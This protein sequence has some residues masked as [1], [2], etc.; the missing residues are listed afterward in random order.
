MRRDFRIVCTS[1]YFD[2]LHVG[3]VEYLESARLLG[4][5]LIVIL[6]ADRQRNAVPRVPIE[7]RI[8]ILKALQVVDQVVVSVDTN[9]HVGETLRQIHPTIFAKGLCASNV[10][11]QVCEDL[12]IEL[13]ENVGKELHMHDLLASLR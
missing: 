12:G 9:A 5:K 10:E 6:N 8:R 3:H 2:P 11:A 4:D 13:V 1:G 7:E